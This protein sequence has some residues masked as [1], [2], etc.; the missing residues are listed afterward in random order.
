MRDLFLALMFYTRIPTPKISNFQP[1]D[2]N[3]TLR[4]YSL[5]GWIIGLIYWLAFLT[6]NWLFNSAVRMINEMESFKSASV[7]KYF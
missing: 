7:T 4:C 3:K 6:G 2:S 1:E 5:V